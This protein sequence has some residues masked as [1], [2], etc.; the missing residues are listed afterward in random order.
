MLIMTA[1]SIVT[2]SNSAAITSTNESRAQTA[3]MAAEYG[4]NQMMARIN[5]Q[6]DSSNNPP[7]VIGDEIA[8]ANS[9]GASYTILPF[10]LPVPPVGSCSDA[11]DNNADLFVSIQGRLNIGS[12]NYRKTIIRTLTVCSPAP[13]KLSVRG[14]R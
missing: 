10:T 3:R 4:F 12:T 7:L 1:L 14:S 11:N 2:R 8:I 5:T 6:Y 13:N 9:T